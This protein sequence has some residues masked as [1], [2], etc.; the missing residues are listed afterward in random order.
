[1]LLDESAIVEFIFSLY[2]NSA[3]TWC[4]VLAVGI[5]KFEPTLKVGVKWFVKLALKYAE[6]LEAIL[7][8]QIEILLY[9][10]LSISAPQ[11]ASSLNAYSLY[12]PSSVTNTI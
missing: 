2:P 4:S 12:V 6:E 8:S 9:S 7:W 11:T 10:R 3:E 1:M 5:T